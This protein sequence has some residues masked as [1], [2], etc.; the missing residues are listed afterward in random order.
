[1]LGLTTPIF[2]QGAIEFMLFVVMIL[3]VAIVTW[4]TIAK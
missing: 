2:D 1:M 3:V 4:L